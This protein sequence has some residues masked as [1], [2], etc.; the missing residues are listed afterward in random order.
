MERNYDREDVCISD[1]PALILLVQWHAVAQQC[2]E[3]IFFPDGCGYHIKDDAPEKAKKSYEEFY[4][5]YDSDQFG[6]YLD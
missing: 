1:V 6:L 4:D 2:I 3:N 5:G